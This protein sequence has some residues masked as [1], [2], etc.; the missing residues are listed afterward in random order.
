VAIRLYAVID[1]D[2]YK[3]NTILID[4]QKLGGYYPGYGAKLIDEGPQPE[5]PKAPPPPPKP[6]DFGVLDVQLAEPMLVGDRIDF[7]TG[8]V[9]KR[10]EPAIIIGEG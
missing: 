7:K 3:I 4:D 8:E 1:A 6:E 9:M 5:E 10:E 2:G